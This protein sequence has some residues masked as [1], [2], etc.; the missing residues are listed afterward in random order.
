MIEVPTSSPAA[1]RSAR[2]RL[3]SHPPTETPPNIELPS[4]EM[5]AP[6]SVLP[7]P[8]TTSLPAPPS[9]KK[10]THLFLNPALTG[11]V[12]FDGQPG[13]DGLRIIVEPRNADDQFI[14]ES[15]TLSVVVLDPTR[16]GEAARL[17]RWD[18]DQPA[19]R[20]LLA[21]NSPRDGMKLELPWPAS[22][23]DANRL[24][25]F[26]RYVT[27]DGR[28][29]QADREVFITHAD[30]AISRWT[31]RST[32]ASPEVAAAAVVAAAPTPSSAKRM[33]PDWSAEREP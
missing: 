15:G 29:L 33:W 21:D 25:L 10:V 6:A 26:V 4:I 32:A 20:Q 27:A 9:D 30:Q 11:G 28:K 12:D 2:P 24:Q 16:Q 18:F 14:N 13:D 31:P 1:G 17:A 7:G 8:K 19:T 5:P 22:P 23:P 3:Q